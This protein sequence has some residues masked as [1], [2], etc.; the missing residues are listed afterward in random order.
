MVE[1]IE[2]V[3]WTLLA[4]LLLAATVS[5]VRSRRIPNALTLAGCLAGVAVSAVAAGLDGLAASGAGLFY[6]FII[7]LPLWLVGW[8][9]AGDVK[10]VS[11]VGAFVG[12]GLVFEVLLAI[13]A[14][15]GVLALVALLARG[16]AARTGERVAATISLSLASRRWTHVAPDAQERDVR[17]PYAVAISAGTLAAVLLF[18]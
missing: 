12:N 4:A 15:G 13:G 11:A 16:L 18:G 10:L 7:T 14:A 3:R 8:L 1:F 5:D 9:G 17:L 6:A 2:P